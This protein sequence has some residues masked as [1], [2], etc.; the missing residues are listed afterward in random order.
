[1]LNFQSICSGGGNICAEYDW[2][3]GL[4][5]N[6]PQPRECCHS[7]RRHVNSSCSTFLP[8]IIKILW[9]V[10]ELQSGHQITHTRRG[11]NSK[12]KKARVVILV[13]NTSS[14]PILHFYQISSKCSKGYS[15]FWAVTNSSLNTERGGGGGGGGG[16]S[17]SKNVKVVILVRGTSSCPLLHFY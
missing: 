16:D 5:L 15:C 11:D 13:H 14:R 7:C 8:R 9:R 3:G 6:P 1:M 12:S 2:L 10:F 4:P 17:K